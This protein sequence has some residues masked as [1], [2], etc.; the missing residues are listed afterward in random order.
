MVVRLTCILNFMELVWFSV[1]VLMQWL[2]CLPLDPTSAGSNPAENVELL[3]A[4]K[5]SSTPSFGEKK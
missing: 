2:A 5:I 4:T 1:V 3:R